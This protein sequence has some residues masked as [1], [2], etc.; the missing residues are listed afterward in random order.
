M[1]ASWSQILEFIKPYLN[2]PIQFSEVYLTNELR[3]AHNH[4]QIKIRFHTHPL[5]LGE[6]KLVKKL[7]KVNMANKTPYV[8]LGIEN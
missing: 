1:F 2:N 7:V 4:H 3:C 8:Y 5:V 6:E